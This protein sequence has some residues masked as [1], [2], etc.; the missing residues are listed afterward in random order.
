MGDD[1]DLD[2]A[3]TC[4][5]IAFNSLYGQWDVKRGEPE[6]D[7]ESWRAFGGKVLDLDHG[8]VLATMLANE[9]KLVL[10]ILDDAYLAGFFWKDPSTGRALQTT[11]DK[12]QALTWYI[13]KRWGLILDATI[14]HVYLLRCQLIHGAATHGSKLNRGSLRRCVA[15]MG[16]LMPA[17][18]TVWIDHGAD[19]DWGELCYPPVG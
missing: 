4:Q 2:L 19:G 12:R 13:E 16:H 3:L 10:A 17:V 5:W 14:E 6:P 1:I 7:R 8:N 9:K 15:F 11:R 18:L